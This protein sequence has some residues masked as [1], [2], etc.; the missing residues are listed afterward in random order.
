VITAGRITVE[1]GGANVVPRLASVSVD[2]RDPDADRLADLGRAIVETAERA[3]AQHDAS[4]SWQ[5]ENLVPPTPLDESVRSV[6]AAASDDLGLSRMDIA[7][8]A[9]HDAQNMAHLAPTAMIFV[10]SRD[11]RSHTP[12]EYTTPQHVEQGANVLLATLLRLAST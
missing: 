11:G 10:P 7:S 1:P 3:A 8:G 12:H 2:Y 4:V 6:I 5:P 9:G